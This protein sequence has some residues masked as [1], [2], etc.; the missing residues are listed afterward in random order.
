MR[1][2]EASKA[3]RPTSHAQGPL[4]CLGAHL[5]APGDVNFAT[6]GYS[7]PAGIF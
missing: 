6:N 7:I 1:A 5:A 2:S 4:A 3:T